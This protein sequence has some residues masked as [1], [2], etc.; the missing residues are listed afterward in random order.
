MDKL[1]SVFSDSLGYECDNDFN[2]RMAVLYNSYYI[3]CLNF[4]DR[5]KSKEIDC[6]YF[7]EQSYMYI[8]K[9]RENK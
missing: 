3:D 8:M 1:K 9:I 2:S 7:K 6:N 5:K 4:K